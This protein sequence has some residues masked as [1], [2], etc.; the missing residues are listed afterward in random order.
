M[1]GYESGRKRM[2]S[3]GSSDSCEKVGKKLTNRDNDED[4]DDEDECLRM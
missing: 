3:S 4:D 2:R 1:A